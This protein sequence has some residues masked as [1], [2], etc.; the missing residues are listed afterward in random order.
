M[1]T[2]TEK[3]IEEREKQTRANNKAR[4]TKRNRLAKAVVSEDKAIVKEA[5][6]ES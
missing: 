3:A 5:G 1:A 4:V 6:K 2:P